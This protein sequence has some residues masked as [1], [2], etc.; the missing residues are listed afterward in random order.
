MF[1]DP[2]CLFFHVRR[3]AWL[4]GPLTRCRWSE[5][6]LMTQHQS[7]RCLLSVSR[8]DEPQ[9]DCDLRSASITPIPA[10]RR[11]KTIRS[12]RKEGLLFRHAVE[13]HWTSGTDR[14]RGSGSFRS[15]RSPR[16]KTHQIL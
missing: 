1:V 6:H 5:H 16:S 8:T 11:E 10:M 12:M 4:G 13:S 14:K 15:L 2:C 7:A 9:G 3:H